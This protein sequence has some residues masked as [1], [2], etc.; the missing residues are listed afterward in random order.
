MSS[1]TLPIVPE[2]KPIAGL[3]ENPLIEGIIG[4]G[5]GQQKE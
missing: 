2:S 4:V 1:E 5:A 3:E